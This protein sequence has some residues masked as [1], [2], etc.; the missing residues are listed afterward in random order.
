M[1][2]L[3]NIQ[4][5]HKSDLFDPNY[6]IREIRTI[7][8]EAAVIGAEYVG[9]DMESYASSPLKQ[10]LGPDRNNLTVEERNKLKSTINAVVKVVG[11]LDFVLPA[12]SG[13][14]L[15]PYNQLAGL[16]NQT[17]A[18]STYWDVGRHLS[19]IRYEYSIFGAYVNTTAAHENRSDLSYYTIESLFAKEYRWSMRKGIMIYPKEHKSFEIAKA[20]VEYAKKHP[21]KN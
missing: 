9:L 11:K 21:V 6:Y 18:E 14:P 2:P 16:G 10:Y 3:Y 13:D 19:Q 8:E 7:R 15:H 20:L 4:T 17:V 12:G 1:W 5:S